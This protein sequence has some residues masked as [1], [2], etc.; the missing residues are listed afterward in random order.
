MCDF[1]AWLWTLK[2]VD[3]TGLMILVLR[4]AKLEAETGGDVREA[5]GR[6][7]Q[8]VQVRRDVR[9]HAEKRRGPAH[10]GVVFL[11]QRHRRESHGPVGEQEHVLRRDGFR[12][13][14][15]NEG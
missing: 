4:G 9:H 12:L 3:S 7:E 1:V 15:V 13:G 5:P 8:A 11:G 10:G 6:P 14:V 2:R